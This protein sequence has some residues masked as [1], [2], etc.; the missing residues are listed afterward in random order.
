MRESYWEPGLSIHQPEVDS[1]RFGMAGF[2][3]YEREHYDLSQCKTGCA[4]PHLL[5]PLR[6]CSRIRKNEIKFTK[7]MNMSGDLRVE[8]SNALIG[9]IL[10]D[11]IDRGQR[12]FRFHNCES[13]DP[14]I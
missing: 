9:L 1:G 3:G 14:A 6:N 13:Q 7:N 12:A 10:L 11:Q 5:H 4:R 2:F 8:N